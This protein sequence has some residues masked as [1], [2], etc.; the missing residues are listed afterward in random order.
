MMPWCVKTSISTIC[1]SH[2]KLLQDINGRRGERHN[3]QQMIIM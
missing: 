3:T 2:S 1:L